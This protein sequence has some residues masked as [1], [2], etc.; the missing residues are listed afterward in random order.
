MRSVQGTITESLSEICAVSSVLSM[1][2]EI[3]AVMAIA[4]MKLSCDIGA[5]TNESHATEL[6]SERL[7]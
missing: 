7:M 2:I 1:S 4:I 3:H 6:A 5:V